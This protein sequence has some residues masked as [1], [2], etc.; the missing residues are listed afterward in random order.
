MYKNKTEF[1][2]ENIDV[3]EMFKAQN[4]A[5]KALIHIMYRE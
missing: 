4:I 3:D 2:Y 5:N 1:D